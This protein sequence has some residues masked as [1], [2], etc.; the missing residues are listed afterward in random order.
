MFIQKLLLIS[1]LLIALISGASAA[2]LNIAFLDVDKA[3]LDTDEAKEFNTK[4]EEELQGELDA[5]KALDAELEELRDRL[6]KEEAILSDSERQLLLSELR[7]KRTRRDG[8]V[9]LLQQHQ[10]QE[11]RRLVEQVSP[12]LTEILEDLIA[13]E[14]YDAVLRFDRQSV[15]Y[16]NPIRDITR[17]VTERLNNL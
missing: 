9:Q 5:V 2:E 4:L 17:K 14:S 11:L 3:I 6:Q 1:V 8:R 16:V 10:Q 13:L 15:L 12:S 7:S